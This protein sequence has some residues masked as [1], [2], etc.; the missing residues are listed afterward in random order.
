VTYLCNTQSVGQA[1]ARNRA[2]QAARG[3]IVS[4]L[5]DDDR[6]LPNHLET[7][8]NALGDESCIFAYT[9]AD[10]VQEV[11]RHG[12]RREISRSTPYRHE[13]WSRRR[14]HIDNYIPI[15]TWGVRKS[16]LDEVG[17][18]DESLSCCEDWELLL[19]IARQYDFRHVKATTVE[20]RHRADQ[21]DNVTRRRLGETQ[22]VYETIYARYDGCTGADVE[23]GRRNAILQ[24]REKLSGLQGVPEG[25]PACAEE[26]GVGA[27]DT[28]ERERFVE[29]S[30]ARGYHCPAIHLFVVVGENDVHRL[31]DTLDALA[32]QI[33]PGWG[34]TVL[35]ALECP[36]GAFEDLPMLEWRQVSDPAGALHAA[37]GAALGEWVGVLNPGDRLAL[38][39]LSTIVDY[40]NL[41]PEWQF[42]YV[43]EDL[44]SD[45]GTGRE[46]CFKPDFN[47]D[48]LLAQPYLGNF[49]LVRKQVQPDAASGLRHLRAI[50]LELCLEVFG[51]DGEGAIGHIP[52]LLNRRA[53]RSGGEDAGAG[54]RNEYATV[55]SGFLEKSGIDAGLTGGLLPDT[56]MVDYRLD[57]EPDVCIA[58]YA[59]GAAQQAAETVASVLGRTE[60]RRYS[61]HIAVGASEA[62]ALGVQ[63]DPRVHLDH[64]AADC[65]R[66]D[67]FNTLAAAHSTQYL[68]FMEPGTVAV[69][70]VWLERML[71]HARRPGIAALGVR[72]VSPEQRV[73]H[74]GIITG[75]GSFAVGTIAF[76]GQR[77][78][79]PGYMNRALVPQEMSAVS[80]ACALMPAR[81]FVEAGGFD[82][83]ID[84]PLFQDIDLCQR[85][86]ERGGK[87]VWTPCVTLLYLG[88]DLGAYRG[89]RGLPKVLED[90]ETLGRRWLPRLARD[91]AYNRNLGLKE[92]DFAPDRQLPPAWNPDIH[93]LPR[94]LGFGAGSYGSWQY[95]AR[96]PLSALQDAG[97]AHCLQT[98]FIHK[99]M[100]LLPTPA[101]I[102]RIRPDA[103]LMHNTLHDDCIE[104]LEKYRKRNR[105]F[106]VFG[107]DDLMFALPPKNPFSKTVYKD[108][109]KRLR[110]CLSLA[111][112]LV[113]TTPVL[114][115]ALE[116]MSNDVHVVPNYLDDGLW[117]GLSAQRH[118]SRKP[119]VGWA[120]A[121]QHLGDLEM[122]E[123]VV[124]ETAAEVDWV[125]FGMCPDCLRPYVSEVHEAVRFEE[126]PAK[127]ASL[128]L[129]LAVAPLEHN[130]FNE[131]KSNLRLLEYGV[132]GWPV[133]ASDIEPYRDAPVCRVPNQPRA[134]TSAIRERVHDLESA[135]REGDRLRDWVRANWM[136]SQHLAEWEQALET[137]QP[138]SGDRPGD[139]LATA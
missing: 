47:L 45:A 78:D 77:M 58:L 51:C 127:L 2:L 39:A 57:A 17:G 68:L 41:Y 73:A 1:R 52:E 61:L 101:E 42:I 88:A 64:V 132:L 82:A 63:R 118:V 9:D 84:V 125:F 71:A 108:V 120:G 97:R 43:D 16:C 13:A 80:S 119:R 34:M 74:G 81:T 72:L 35:S 114:G 54:L 22:A 6:Y 24:L 10:M 136:L 62:D 37:M 36:A 30:A 85:L 27:R 95:R 107:Q 67:Y 49:C 32:G 18:F 128:N 117:Q 76:Q 133:V 99:N 116:S 20:V 109:R 96:Q 139:R 26:S 130:R 103:L 23:E 87:V 8:V 123:Q 12:E 70:D 102:E 106:V 93:D 137:A 66:A 92:L 3:E 50:N 131:A 105:A 79:D 100:I 138:V 90:A 11:I 129:D 122:I 14:L 56:F 31:G 124:R 94:F 69:Q 38:N 33:Y 7:L 25:A 113:V 134:W 112:R 135:W 91:P 55:I 15:N 5:D 40:V 53:A 75:V 89:R 59:V 83:N 46:D 44:S 48:Y 115:A 110:R 21:A 111:D 86:R 98:P 121:Q 28:R 19:R 4:F 104:A 65:T 60:Y 126:Y 29:R